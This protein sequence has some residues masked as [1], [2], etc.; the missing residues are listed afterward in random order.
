MP[1][2]FTWAP[3]YATVINTGN[4]NNT[5]TAA[6]P[7]ATTNTLTPSSTI[8]FEIGGAK[9][10]TVT[11]QLSISITVDASTPTVVTG[12]AADQAFVDDTVSAAFFGYYISTGVRSANQT[13]PAISIKVK[14][15]TGETANRSYYL[16]GNG[17]TTPTAQS[18]LTIAPAATTTF[19][20]TTRNAIRCGPNYSTN[21]ITGT[22]MNCAAGSTVASMDITQFVKILYSDPTSAAIISQLEF[23]AVAE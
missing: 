4:L 11:S 19:V 2:L 17:T 14:K 18:N 7:L 5:T 9:F 16:L 23:T 13:A 10:S 21:G 12:T 22:A 20:S 1:L 15:G 8:R 6:S 3:V